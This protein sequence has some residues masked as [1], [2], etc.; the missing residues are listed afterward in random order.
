M[1]PRMDP[2]VA[3]LVSR[4][5]FH[6]IAWKCVLITLSLKTSVIG[7]NEYSFGVDVNLPY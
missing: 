2:M 1:L 6:I 3:D 4:Q 5:F 7:D